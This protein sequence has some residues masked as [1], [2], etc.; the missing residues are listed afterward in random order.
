MAILLKAGTKLAY[1]GKE[2]TLLYLR[3]EMGASN[4]CTHKLGSLKE[5]ED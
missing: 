1:L 3:T 4:G 2:T 5:R